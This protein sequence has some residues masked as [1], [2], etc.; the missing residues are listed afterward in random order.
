MIIDFHTHCF[1]DNLAK[2]AIDTLSAISNIDHFTNGTISGLKDSMSQA[3]IDYSVVLNIVVKKHQT[4]KTNLF[5][6]GLL[7][8][9]NPDYDKS[10]IPFASIHPDDET[11]RERLV[12]LK[13]DGFKGIK[14]HPDYQ[15]FSINDYKM[16]PIYTEI[17]RLGLILV[18]HSGIDI[19]YPESVGASPDKIADVLPLLEKC[20]TVLAHMGAYGQYKDVLALLCNKNIFFD[21][22]YSLDKMG[23]ETARNIIRKHGFEKILFGTDSPWVNQAFYVNYLRNNICKD[24]LSAK[25]VNAILGGNASSLLGL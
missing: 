23:D 3:K 21:T 19:G 5:A 1:P 25:Q 12:K 6:R 14:L 20:K 2:S 15:G 9:N 7:D 22:S 13:A 10:I 16:E 18:F 17:A 8:K 4:E 11:W 24:F